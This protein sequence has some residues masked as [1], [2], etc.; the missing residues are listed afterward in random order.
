MSRYFDAKAA[1]ARVRHNPIRPIHPNPNCD[2][3]QNSTNSVNRVPP[4]V[5][6]FEERA[7]IVEYVA[8]MTRIEAEDFA[9]Q[10]QGFDNVISFKAAIRKPPN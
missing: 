4:D 9:A 5:D 6:A 7:A 3:R 8:G 2:E 1:F 10:L